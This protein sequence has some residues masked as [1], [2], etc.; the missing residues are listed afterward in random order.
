MWSRWPPL[1]RLDQKEQQQVVLIKTTAPAGAGSGV[2][3]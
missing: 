3:L 1:R 2:A